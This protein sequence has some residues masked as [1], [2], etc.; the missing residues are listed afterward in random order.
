MAEPAR[1]AVPSGIDPAPP[2]AAVP[3]A[4]REA[5]MR[6]L[7][8]GC[9]IGGALAAGNVYASLKVGIID[10]GSI[11]AV[12]LGFSLFAT[13]KRLGR[14]PYGVLENNITQ[15][16]ASS[17]AVM[18]FST[19]IVGPIPAL[20]L[21]GHTYPGWAVAV[22]GVAI[23]L[24]GIFAATL[25]RRRL[26]VDEALPFP[27]GKATG[28]L[29][30]TIHNARETA[31]TPTLFLIAAMVVAGAITWFRDG[32]PSLIPEQTV[33]PFAIAGFAA[34]VLTLGMSWSPLMLSIGAMVGLR[35]AGSMLLGAVLARG[36]FAPWVAGNGWVA[37]AEYGP[38]NGWL[39]W[40]AI[41]LMVA[42]SFMP[43]VLGAGAVTRSFRDLAFLRRAPRAGAGPAA[44]RDPALSARL[45]TPL[46]AVSLAAIFVLGWRAFDVQPVAMLIALIVALILINVAARATGETDLTPGGATGTMTQASVAGRGAATS[47]L[48]GSLSLGTASMAA[49]MLWAYRAGSRVGASPRAQLAAQILGALVGAAVIMPVYGLIVS[50]YGLATEKM[51][52]T[53]A[54]SWK[55][56][57]EALTGT[58]VLPPYAVTALL[59]ALGVGIVLTFLART[60]LGD[61]VPAPTAMG[62]AMMLPF[63]LSTAAFV[64]AALVA[65]ARRIRP[66][67]E[68]RT[69]MAAAAGG[70]AGESLTGVLVM[71]LKA[72][73]LLPS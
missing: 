35:G 19:G 37:S 43:L 32:R 60:R 63:W 28:E 52:S 14:R 21:M 69:V 38:T 54:L 67:T 70:L 41:G 22:W 20:A 1:A 13:F 2:S 33:F 12:L 72:T 26:I 64:G 59:L 48:G 58:A 31:R 73:G 42:G 47:I 53:S 24:V 66:G 34:G 62:V 15:T 55:A 30:E 39:V 7:L 10:G 50:T 23:T 40:P 11:T 71:V 49:Q 8:T 57:A 46:L 17:A 61:R 65:I 68:D 29:L 44:A 18:S 9:V 5:T 51:P 6:A 45:W 16:V 27:T 4:P 36:V 3:T 25:L 56:T